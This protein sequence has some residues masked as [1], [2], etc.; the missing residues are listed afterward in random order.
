MSQ[1]MRQMGMSQYM[2][3]V[4]CRL[5]MV[6]VFAHA[7]TR[8]RILSYLPPISRM[9]LCRAYLA[10]DH[11]I[12]NGV[13]ESLEAS[14]GKELYEDIMSIPGAHI[15]GSMLLKALTWEK[16]APSDVDVVIPWKKW[17]HLK[18]RTALWKPWASTTEHD[19][20]PLVA[21]LDYHIHPTSKRR[22]DVIRLREGCN[23]DH[24]VSH[25]DL[26]GLEN[27]YSL[28]RGLRVRHPDAILKRYFQWTQRRPMSTVLYGRLFKYY[29][30]RGYNGRINNKPLPSQ[31]TRVLDMVETLYP[32]YSEETIRN[33]MRAVARHELRANGKPTDWTDTLLAKAWNGYC[34]R[35]GEKQ[36]APR[37][38]RRR[39]RHAHRQSKRARLA[40][41]V[42]ETIIRME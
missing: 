35:H 17:D 8:N 30:L 16:W 20:H 11:L 26:D 12:D 3:E 14:M 19:Y 37:P 32:S 15:T 2:S 22:V 39:K 6:K 24:F 31:F 28:K 40:K 41:K 33:A 13:R 4:D 42:A 34:I 1:H 7:C 27:Y 9:A 36:R 38:K 10:L 23:I 21:Q 18:N 29:V 25:F 5:D